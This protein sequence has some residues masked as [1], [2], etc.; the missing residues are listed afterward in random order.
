MCIQE[1]YIYRLLDLLH[2]Q[3]FNAHCIAYIALAKLCKNGMAHSSIHMFRCNWPSF[4]TFQRCS[5]AFLWTSL[6]FNLHLN[7]SKIIR[8]SIKA[9]LKQ[10]C[11][12]SYLSWPPSHRLW[13][14]WT[15][16]QSTRSPLRSDSFRCRH[17]P[18]PAVQPT[19][20]FSGNT[21]MKC[22]RP[23]HWTISKRQKKQCKN[24]KTTI[25]T[26]TPLLCLEK[27]H[28]CT[29]SPGPHEWTKLSKPSW[30]CWAVLI[31]SQYFVPL[32]SLY[33]SPVFSR[34]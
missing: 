18:T 24:T 22:W 2:E 16:L 13:W 32:N 30:S 11:F 27:L 3:D 28:V 12:L 15:H 25:R 33:I 20:Y 9:P 6:L 31:S 10:S 5:H 19:L 14:I 29:F 7:H 17:F 8:W 26:P 34:V 23:F 21:E 1:G 4:C